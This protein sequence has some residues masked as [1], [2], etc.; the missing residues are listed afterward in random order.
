M[1]FN[2]LPGS[3]LSANTQSPSGYP[4]TCRSC[5]AFPFNGENTCSTSASVNPVLVAGGNLVHINR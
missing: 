3:D 2:F 5:E 4:G 1:L